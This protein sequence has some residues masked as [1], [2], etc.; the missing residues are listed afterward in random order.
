MPLGKHRCTPQH[1]HSPHSSPHSNMV[2]KGT[3]GHWPHIVCPGSQGGSHTHSRHARHGRYPHAHMGWMHTHQCYSC[4]RGL[5]Y[6]VGMC[7]LRILGDTEE[8]GW[9]R[10]IRC[11]TGTHNHIKEK[12]FLIGSC[13]DALSLC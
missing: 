11:N 3:P 7:S 8:Q 10:G 12:V 6:P 9:V 13:Y 1:Q 2:R 4:T 5:V